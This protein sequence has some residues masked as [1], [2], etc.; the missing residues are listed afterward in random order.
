MTD[1]DSEDVNV[2]REGKVGKEFHANTG[3]CHNFFS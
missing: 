2:A 1:L 3:N